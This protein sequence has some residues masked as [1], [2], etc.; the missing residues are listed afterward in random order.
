MILFPLG[1]TE[2]DMEKFRSVEYQRT[3]QYLKLFDAGVNLDNFTFQRQQ[4]TVIGDPM[5]ALKI[6]IK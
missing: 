6:A 4:Q 1:D 5:E 3:F 2:F